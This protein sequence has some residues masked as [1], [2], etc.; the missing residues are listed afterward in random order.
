MLSMR[1]KGHY[2]TEGAPDYA[3][4]LVG[5]PSIDLSVKFVKEPVGFDLL[6]A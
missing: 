4:S 2:A 6:H 3:S 1:G 5:S